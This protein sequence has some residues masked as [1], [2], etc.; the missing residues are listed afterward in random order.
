MDLQSKI[1]SARNAGYSDA[2]IND[3]LS[4][5]N[6]LP[7][8]KVGGL[9]GAV[10]NALPIATG[11]AGTVLGGIAGS[12]V[13]GAGNV[14][15]AVG[16]GAIG[17]GF[18]EFL[19][20]KLSGEEANIGSIAREGAFGA[21][22]GVGRGVKAVRAAKGVIAGE[23]AAQTTEAAMQ[24]RKGIVGKI[25]NNAQQASQE[26]F[27]VTVGQSA[28]RGKVLTPDKAD[29]LQDF[30]TNRSQQYGGIRAG[31]PIDQARDAQKVLSGVTK[32]LDDTLTKI[33]RPLQ[34]QEP[35]SV[36]ARALEIAKDNAAITKATPTLEK[37][38]GKIE[39]AKSLKELEA[40]RRE[41]DD[42]AFASTGAGK[43]SAAAQSHAVRDAI[44]EFITPLSAEYKA[45]KGDYSLARD[46]LES[47]SKASKNAKGFTM[48]FTG[49]EVGKQTISGAQNKVA[50]KLS[51]AGS[52]PPTPS[53]DA[54]SFRPFL[55]QTAKATVPQVGYRAAGSAVL[56]TP[57]V[58]TGQA[59]ETQ[60]TEGIDSAP[61]QQPSPNQPQ[62]N[63]MFDPAN[64]QS[65]VQQII[66]SGGSVKDA[67]EYV[68]LVQTLQQMNPSEKPL[69]AEASKVVANA[70]S[71]LTSLSQLEG[72]INEQG[73]VSKGTLV[74]GR[75]LFGGLG[76][77]VLGTAE[78]DTAAKNLTDVITRLRT[79]AA[80]TNEE[81]AFY[82]S[83]VPQAF[84]SPEV[85]QQKIQMF[86]DLFS[87]VASR[88][89][90]AGTDLQ[91]AAGL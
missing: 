72:I 44:D 66:A 9:R 4:K 21:L 14:A 1:S 38:K 45:I 74:P 65:A 86:K 50:A 51:G 82:Q 13:P 70:N 2:Q 18:G 76:A 11:A 28:G 22:G 60:P 36:I 90:S 31:K 73:G 15:G 91:Q 29:E 42:L 24:A 84:D 55:S 64:V 89:G 46:A 69:S 79:G 57:F 61:L 25:K 32:S 40:I 10:L 52:L 81:A 47:T 35:S 19:R 20:Q 43:T 59:E 17:S 8:K 77:N 85:R 16:G 49:R 68:N 5:S 63:P 3:Y 41:A 7:K 39:K 34:V 12:V 30:I 48:P 53:T 26:G 56:G 23:K 37:F 71:G 27:G 54:S 88:S 83:Q 78:Y 33:D 87:S 67:A 6:M 80:L 58:G 75:S 62:P